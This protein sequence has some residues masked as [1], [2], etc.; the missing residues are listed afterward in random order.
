MTKTLQ[1]VFPSALLLPSISSPKKTHRDQQGI[2]GSRDQGIKGIQR[3]IYHS[4]PSQ[5]PVG[6][7]AHFLHICPRVA[8]PHQSSSSCL[9]LC[10]AFFLAK[11]ASAKLPAKLGVAALPSPFRLIPESLAGWNEAGFLAPGAGLFPG[12]V[13]AAGLPPFG[14]PGGGGGA[15]GAAAGAGACSS[16]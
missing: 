4:S 2:G 8:L 11:S 12:G 7:L 15:R 13:G 14:R 6:S 9:R 1:I 5:R 3:A 10:M 16:T